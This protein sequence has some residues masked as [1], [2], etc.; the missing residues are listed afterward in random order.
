M[1]GIMT[2]GLCCSLDTFENNHFT[3]ERAAAYNMSV[4]GEPHF[5]IELLNVNGN[6]AVRQVTF[7]LPTHLHLY[8]K[9][10]KG[11][12]KAGSQSKGV[13]WSPS[14]SMWGEVWPSPPAS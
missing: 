8:F 9:G 4:F 1:L 13:S 3:T 5:K 2:M 10:K 7:C 11:W 12:A 6:S 14:A